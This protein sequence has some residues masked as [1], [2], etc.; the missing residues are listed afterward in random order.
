MEGVDRCNVEPLALLFS[1]VMHECEL[2]M[3]ID[4]MT[5]ENVRYLYSLK[6]MFAYKAILLST[7]LIFCFP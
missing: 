1:H 6:S 5:R 7:N 3:I 4:A 2:F